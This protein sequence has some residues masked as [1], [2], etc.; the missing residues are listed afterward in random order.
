MFLVTVAAAIL[1]A[2]VLTVI[3]THVANRSIAQNLVT[4][5]VI[6]TVGALALLAVLAV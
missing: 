5:G 1:F 3:L 4:A 6:L 2:G